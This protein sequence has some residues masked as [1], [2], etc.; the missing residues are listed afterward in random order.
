[1][2]QTPMPRSSAPI[3]A[4]GSGRDKGSYGIPWSVKTII[5]REA[6]AAQAAQAAKNDDGYREL[7]ANEEE[8]MPF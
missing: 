8:G 1:M 5:R 2:P 4:S 6:L 7:G 3:L